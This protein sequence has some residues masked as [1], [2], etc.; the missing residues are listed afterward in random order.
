VLILQG[1]QGLNVE[2]IQR[3]APQSF[4]GDEAGNG[5]DPRRSRFEGDPHAALPGLSDDRVGGE[6]AVEHQDIRSPLFQFAEPVDLD[7]T[8]FEPHRTWMRSKPERRQGLDAPAG[9]LCREDEVN[10]DG[11]PRTLVHHQCEAAAEGVRNACG[12]KRLEDCL[13]FDVEINHG[14]PSLPR[15]GCGA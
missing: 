14:G 11:C 9:D 1:L 12:F 15:F 6:E 5:Y 8:G 3:R 4:Q 7:S 10:V 13:E 2:Q